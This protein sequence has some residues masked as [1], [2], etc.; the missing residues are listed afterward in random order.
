[1]F[2]LEMM[3][4]GRFNNI[5]YLMLI[6]SYDDIPPSSV[7]IEERYVKTITNLIE[8]PVRLKPP[9]AALDNVCIKVCFALYRAYN[10]DF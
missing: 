7:P 4:K 9:N 6:F 5:V 2:C 10:I 1:M 3:Q 8:H